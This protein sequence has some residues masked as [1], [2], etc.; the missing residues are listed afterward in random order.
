MKRISSVGPGKTFGD[1]SRFKFACVAKHVLH[2]R[3][4]LRTSQFRVR[5][6]SIKSMNILDYLPGYEL[7]SVS[8]SHNH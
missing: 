3:P 5:L 2:E 1:K 7:T 4:S 6:R 8:F